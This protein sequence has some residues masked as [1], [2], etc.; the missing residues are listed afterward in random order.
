MKDQEQQ[1]PH[2]LA[3]FLFR[4]NPREEHVVKLNVG[5]VLL[6]TSVQT[7]CKYPDSLLSILFADGNELNRDSSGCVFLD[8]NGKVFSYMLDWLRRSVLG[9]RIPVSSFLPSLSRESQHS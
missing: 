2:E 6:T 5:G 3:A 1:R 9:L 7:L 8:R 4:V